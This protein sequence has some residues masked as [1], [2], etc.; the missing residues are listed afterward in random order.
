MADYVDSGLNKIGIKISKPML[1]IICIIFGIMV[2]LF[3]DLLVD[4]RIVS[5]SSRNTAID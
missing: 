3:P 5:S 2:I 4:S 1:A